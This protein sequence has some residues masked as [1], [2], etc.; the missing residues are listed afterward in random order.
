MVRVEQR[1]LCSTLLQVEQIALCSIYKIIADLIRQDILG[2]LFQSSPS[3]TTGR[4]AVGLF[5]ACWLLCAD[6]L[7]KQEERLKR[8]A[9]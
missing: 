2:N 6:S 9:K 3:L 4:F 8:V 7:P 1:A 5:I